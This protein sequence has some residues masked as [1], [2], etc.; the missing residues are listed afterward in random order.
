MTNNPR[1]VAE[2]RRFLGRH[3]QT[4]LV[5]RPVEST[6]VLTGWLAS[7]RAVLA[8]E[9]NLFDP[10]GD[11]VR[12][13]YVGPARNICRLH[14]WVLRSIR[15]CRRRWAT[16]CGGRKPQGWRWGLVVRAMLIP[17]QPLGGPRLAAAALADLVERSPAWSTP[18]RA[19]RERG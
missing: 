10:A 4:L 6:D 15:G 7:A 16:R 11:L 19:R 3:A 14:A 1:K 12:P 5:E 2:Y 8:D 13:G 18:L 17:L 9:S